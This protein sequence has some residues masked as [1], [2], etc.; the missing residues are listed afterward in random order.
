MDLTG[1][2]EAGEATVLAPG[3]NVA[4]L[5]PGTGRLAISLGDAPVRQ[6]R[7]VSGVRQRVDPDSAASLPLP[8]HVRV[9][10]DNVRGV[11][12]RR[13]LIQT[14]LTRVR[15]DDHQ[16]LGVRVDSVNEVRT[17]LDLRGCIRAMRRSADPRL[18]SDEPNGDLWVTDM[19]GHVACN[20]RVGLLPRACVLVVVAHPR[21]T[22]HARGQ[23]RN[24][25]RR[26]IDQVEAKAND[27]A[28]AVVTLAEEHAPQRILPS[29]RRGS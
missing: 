19:R 26:G 3:L 9:D 23:A 11:F 16:R 15:V 13:N 29:T 22:F 17:G 8:A 4:Q 24:L 5:L 6:T 20:L 28:K 18:I 27:V 21:E 7:H 2:R 14:L 10:A 25:A 1:S 12:P